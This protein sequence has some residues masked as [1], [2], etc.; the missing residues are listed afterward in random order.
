VANVSYGMDNRLGAAA[1]CKVLFIFE[2]VT[3]VHD[4]TL[5]VRRDPPKGAHLHD[6]LLKI[7]K[8][9]LEGDTSWL[10]ALGMVISPRPRRPPEPYS[11]RRLKRWRR[12]TACCER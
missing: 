7:L 12:R 1:H 4:I 10:Q 9:W 2:T 8:V 5:S 3:Q 6:L 11:R